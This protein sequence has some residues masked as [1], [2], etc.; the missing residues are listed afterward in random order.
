MTRRA[1]L[2]VL[3]AVLVGAGGLTAPGAP[4]AE[5]VFALNLLGERFNVGDARTAALGG[6]VQLMDDSLGVLQ[7]NPATIAWAKRVTFGVSG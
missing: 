6:F 2:L 4:R 1:T 7:Y 5:S 3:C